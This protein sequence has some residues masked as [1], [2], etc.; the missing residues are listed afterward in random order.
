MAKWNLID[1][2]SAGAVLMNSKKHL[3]EVVN[4][5]WGHREEEDSR[6]RFSED[7]FLCR[8]HTNFQANLQVYSWL[9][10]DFS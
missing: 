10:N 6:V 9:N 2:L 7:M 5:E 4:Q 3:V 8:F 1:S